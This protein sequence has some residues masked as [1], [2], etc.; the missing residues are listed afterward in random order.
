[1]ASVAGLGNNAAGTIY[2]GASSEGML[3]DSGYVDSQNSNTVTLG[4]N[5][6][7]H[8]GSGVEVGISASPV[9]GS[10]ASIADA[11]FVAVA[12]N[13]V[14]VGADMRGRFVRAILRNRV[15]ENT[16]LSYIDL[17]LNSPNEK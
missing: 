12:V 9:V 6:S 17:E 4:V 8:Q 16:A 2:F 10:R 1:M 5:V 7:L 15:P 14:I 13:E 3:I 11:Q